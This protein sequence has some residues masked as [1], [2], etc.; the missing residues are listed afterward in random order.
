MGIATSEAKDRPAA[1]VARG[2]DREAPGETSPERQ[3]DALFLEL[4]GEPEMAFDRRRRDTDADAGKVA[5]DRSSS[6]LSERTRPARGTAARVLLVTGL[7]L[8]A[9]GFLAAM[10]VRSPGGSVFPFLTLNAAAVLCITAAVLLL[11]EKSKPRGS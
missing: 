3:L 6:G 10:T 11:P 5:S 1:P 7:F 9:G 2:L 8:I 4:E